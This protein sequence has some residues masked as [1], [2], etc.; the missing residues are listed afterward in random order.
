MK[1]NHVY[2]LDDRAEHVLDDGLFCPCCPE[3]RD[4]WIVHN[5]YDGRELGELC[6]GALDL[7]GVA[8]A[9][10]H[11]VWSDEERSLFERALDCLGRH[12]PSATAICSVRKKR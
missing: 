12:Y 3:L 6:V 11:H 9:H 7:L 2:P 8:L 1:P 5:S 4:G 10:H